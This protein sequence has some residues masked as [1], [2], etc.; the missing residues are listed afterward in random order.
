MQKLHGPEPDSD[1]VVIDPLWNTK[2]KDNT[3]PQCKNGTPKQKRL[4]LDITEKRA[5]NNHRELIERI[6]THIKRNNM[7]KQEVHSLRDSLL[8]T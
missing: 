4:V 3:Y 7:T 2:A 1:Y 5:P 6:A 8:S